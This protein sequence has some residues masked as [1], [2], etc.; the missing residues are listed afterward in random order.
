MSYHSPITGHPSPS[1]PQ[2]EAQGKPI[3]DVRCALRDAIVYLE[4]E[5]VSSAA[6]AAELLLMHIL[7]K[8]RAWLYAHPEHELDADTSRQYFS[9]LAQRASGVPTQYLTGHHEFWG[10]DFEVTPAVLIPRPETE[11]VIEVALERLGIT[12]DT[13]AQRCSDALRIADVGTG[14][15]C[16][17]I[18]LAH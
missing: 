14:S 2:G 9:L 17:A 6:L 10:L 3:M 7:D 12:A 18:A 8:D 1:V 11:H 15:G 13:A 16:I 5:H 4:R